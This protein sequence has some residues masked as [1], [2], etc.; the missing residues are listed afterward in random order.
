MRT[1]R[2]Q[3]RGAQ[4][5]AA[6]GTMTAMV[7]HEFNNI[8]T[9][10]VNY[11]QLARERPE[12]TA[13][14]LACTLSG[15]KRATDICEAILGMTRSATDEI[16]PFRVRDIIDETL[17]GMARDLERDSIDLVINVADDLTLDARRIELQQVV[18]NLLLNAR[19]AVLARPTPRRIEISARDEPQGVL[20]EVRDNGIGIS[21]KNLNRV[22]EP[23]FTTR[24]GGAD[25]SSGSGLGL[26]VC[27]EII[28]S[29]NGQITVRSTEGTGTTFSLR[30]PQ[31]T[32]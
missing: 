3:L 19:Q 2:K 4:R 32:T 23:F 11:A 22:F 1:L 27:R 15:G 10:I 5:L 29:M 6:V 14:A 7:V 21:P 20:L 17:T 25:C 12:M 16:Q 8:L 30:F 26:A 24:K 31:A 13:K 18:L 28:Q 9:P